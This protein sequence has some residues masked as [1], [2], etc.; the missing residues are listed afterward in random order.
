M[1]LS[2]PLPQ[3][4][5]GPY[6]LDVPFAWSYTCPPVGFLQ[7][8]SNSKSRDFDRVRRAGTEPKDP[9]LLFLSGHPSSDWLNTIGYVYNVD[10][11]FFQQ[12]LRSI[13]PSVHD[14][15]YAEPSLPSGSRHTLKLSIPTI[16]SLSNAKDLFDDISRARSLLAENL[17][18]QFLENVQNPPVGRPIVRSAYLH[19]R[20][21]FT[22][23]QEVSICLLQE[24]GA[25]TSTAP[26]LL[27][28]SIANNVKY[29]S[30][31]MLAA[32]TKTQTFP[33]C[34]SKPPENLRSTS[35]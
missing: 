29:S 28:M 2:N 7:L 25:W 21:Q 35:S 6:T 13:R 34:S 1:Y 33:S 26:R 32:K 12:H 4:P 9:E 24:T 30:G 17:K 27:R 18:T 10:I 5:I 16:G 20:K 22:L 11:H 15:V 8:S 14:R 3:W 31:L 23:V 19:N